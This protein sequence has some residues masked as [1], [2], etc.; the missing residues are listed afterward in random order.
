VL[1]P[2]C[3]EQLRII[4]ACA[5]LMYMKKRKRKGK[6]F[7]DEEYKAESEYLAVSMNP[8][9]D[10]E[11]FTRWLMRETGKK[12]LNVT[13]S[14]LD[15]GSGNGRN[16]V[17]L[18]QTFEMRGIG[19]D[20]SSE[21]VKQARQYAEDN[22]LPIEYTARSIAGDLDIPDNSQTLVLDMMVSHFL[23]AD[24]RTY[25]RNE[26]Y[27]V[28]RP[29]GFLFYKTFL[30]D[31]DK[32]ARRMIKENP[33]EEKNSYIHPNIGVPEHVSTEDEIIDA[34]SEKYIVHKVYKSHRHKGKT[35]KRRSI[36]VYLQKPEY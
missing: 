10:L 9:E 12:Y 36:S 6:G 27:R 1:V 17:W 13:A 3:E 18:A 4:H 14:V 16:L 25:L 2:L 7:W 11:K 35:A 19:Y 32:H 15:L 29:G 26:I 21:G 31:E 5:S 28:L 34:F 22:N 23:N 24:E 20:I 33:A 30:L 8:S